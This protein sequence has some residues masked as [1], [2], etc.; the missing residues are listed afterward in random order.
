MSI[1][2]AELLSYTTKDPN[3]PIVQLLKDNYV[4][5]RKLREFFARAGKHTSLLNPYENL[6]SVFDGQGKADIRFRACTCETDEEK[7]KYI[8]RLKPESCMQD[9]LPAIVKNLNEF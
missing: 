4:Y 7:G 9:G 5:E 2:L 3:I 6:F 8:L 1:T